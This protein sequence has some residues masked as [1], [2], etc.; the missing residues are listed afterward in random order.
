MLLRLPLLWSAVTTPLETGR[1]YH[2]AATYDSYFMRLYVDGVQVCVRAQKGLP[3]SPRQSAEDRLLIPHSERS[4][5]LY[6]EG[7][8][9]HFGY[10]GVHIDLKCTL[11]RHSDADCSHF[12]AAICVF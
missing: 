1:W 4:F 7:P 12:L 10:L 8:K 11:F 3:L 5:E 6:C 2:L 9:V